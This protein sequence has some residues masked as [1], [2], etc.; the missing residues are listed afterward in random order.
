MKEFIKD[1]VKQFLTEAKQVGVLYHFTI[2][3]SNF[4]LN[5]S[6]TGY[7]SF[8][9]NKM[10]SSDSISK[11]V[12]IKIDGDKLSNN[13]RIEPFAD[14]DA[15]YG[16]NAYTTNWDE[17]EERI[18]L[19]YDRGVDISK[20]ILGIDVMIPTFTPNQYDDD[21]ES[22]F[23]PPSLKNFNELVAKIKNTG[24]KYNL[25]KNYKK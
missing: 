23:G 22:S 12:R 4:I 5:K 16:R 2:I 7:I 18:A 6:A 8:T 20:C 21:D 17:S 1:K 14:T 25:V 15:G 13:N 3:D 9:R 24:L 11:D 19:R 10:M